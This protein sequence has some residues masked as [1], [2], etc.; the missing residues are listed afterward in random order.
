MSDSIEPIVVKIITD[1]SGFDAGMDDAIK[2]TN[3]LKK[4]ASGSKGTLKDYDRALN[5]TGDSAEEASENID[6]MSAAVSKA[7]TTAQTASTN[8]NSLKSAVEKEGDAAER[9][10]SKNNE[11]ADKVDKLGKKS[12]DADKDV[13]GLKD[14]S[15]KLKNALSI[16]ALGGALIAAA[17]WMLEL[18][19]TS[20]ETERKFVA[21]YKSIDESTDALYRYKDA[22]TKIVG[23]T[24]ESRTE[25]REAVSRAFSDEN[26]SEEYQIALTQKIMDTAIGLGVS[27]K[28]LTYDLEEVM[29]KYGI[30]GSEVIPLLDQLV[31]LSKKQSGDQS[32]NY[33]ENIQG[34]L[35]NDDMFK[36]MG[37]SLD[38]ALKFF[39]SLDNE[40]NRESVS[41]GTGLVRRE[42][43]AQQNKIADAQTTLPELEA[44]LAQTIEERD[45]YIDE[46]RERIAEGKS[47]DSID[48]KIESLDNTISGVKDAIGEYQSLLN[49]TPGVLASELKSG[50][51]YSDLAGKEKEKALD[52]LKIL[53]DS[54]G[55]TLPER[56]ESGWNYKTPEPTLLNYMGIGREKI[57]QWVQESTSPDEKLQSLRNTRGM[58]YHEV[59]T[60]YEDDKSI[61]DDFAK[62][63]QKKQAD[64]NKQYVE[65]KIN[66]IELETAL[67]DY[68][69]Q[70]MDE[71]NALFGDKAKG[72]TNPPGGT[73]VAPKKESRAGTTGHTDI[74]QTLEPLEPKTLKDF[75]YA[76]DDS[77]DGINNL[78]EV[79]EPSAEY[80]DIFNTNTTAGTE[81]VDI[82]NKSTDITY[83]RLLACT[84]Q[85]TLFD[86]ANIT[87]AD[88][89]ELIFIPKID[90][91]NGRLDGMISRLQRIIALQSQ[92]W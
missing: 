87:A 45:A 25:T 62:D 56:G 64:L 27:G 58:A 38:D 53:N 84:D 12:K 88:N 32:E 19:Q 20:A 57:F 78:N 77:A 24:V 3:D 81:I 8:Q 23:G 30:D 9:S 82:F 73:S 65:D 71:Y 66:A 63:Y 37:L 18:Q 76:V 83:E 35:E 80:L 40:E 89:L 41:V 67:I 33:R 4:A 39:G 26:Q 60:K 34:L 70:K 51:T 61:L 42:W 5:D 72:D 36:S 44:E 55:Y 1:T 59:V 21:L 22:N 6:E 85:M 52:V 29:S 43:L 91:T 2:A 17:D 48:K 10:G 14:A 15:N 69:G 86:T 79:L 49:A 47:I 11:A 90:A 74:Y 50:A 75:G 46:R 92:V 13:L 68:I 31:E 54:G 28:D 16:T 7:S